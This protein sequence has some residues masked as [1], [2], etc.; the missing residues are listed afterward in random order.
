MQQEAL[1]LPRR[2]E[3]RPVSQGSCR[4]RVDACVT[5]GEVMAPQVLNSLVHLPTTYH[6][7]PTTY[8]L[9]PTT[10]YLP[11]TTYYLPPTTYYLPPTI[12]HLPPT[13]YY[14]PPTTY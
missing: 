11:P 4:Q 1:L 3:E 14:L 9:L 7:L 2:S 8:H 13:T 6:L 12:Y 5:S 10:Y